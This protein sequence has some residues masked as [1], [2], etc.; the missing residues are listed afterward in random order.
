[1]GNTAPVVWKSVNS[2]TPSYFYLHRDNQSS[3]LAI[4]NS[5]GAIIEKRLFDPWG[6]IVAVQDGA[7]NNLGKL[8]FFDRGYT[9]H[10]HL[11]GVGLINMN[12]RL[13]DPRLHRFLQ[14][15]NFVQDTSNTQNYNRYGYVLN[16]PLKYPRSAKFDLKTWGSA[17]VSRPRSDI[18]KKSVQKELVFLKSKYTSPLCAKS[19]DLESIL[20]L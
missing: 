20:K 18:K 15:D 16:N 7:G 8:T 14:A 3:I 9:G 17:M 6:N 5:A 19:P 11:Q 13:Y 12:A 4:T 10:E 2:A 1:M